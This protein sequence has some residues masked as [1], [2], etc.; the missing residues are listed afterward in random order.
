MIFANSGY[1]ANSPEY[2]AD[3]AILAYS[4]IYAFGETDN[5]NVISLSEEDITEI[6][7]QLRAKFV[8]EFKEFCLN[9]ESVN[10][11]TDV[12]DYLEDYNCLVILSGRVFN[13]DGNKYLRFV[14]YYL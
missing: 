3:K 12:Y 13:S 1:C 5:A 7:E 10:K 9:E 4:E 14:D 8:D 2:S 6:K 11:L